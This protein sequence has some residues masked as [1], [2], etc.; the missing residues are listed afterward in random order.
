[1]RLLI[2]SLL[3]LAS[4]SHLEMARKPTGDYVPIIED[5]DVNDPLPQRGNNE[6]VCPYGFYLSTYEDCRPMRVMT[7][8]VISG[9][10]PKCPGKYTFEG[11][12]H[13]TQNKAYWVCQL[14]R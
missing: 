14:G 6:L 7:I 12:T 8:P 2:A 5:T 4:C 11:S 10:S 3:F 1:M 9:T 13:D